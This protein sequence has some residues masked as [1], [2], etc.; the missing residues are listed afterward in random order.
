MSIKSHNEAH[1]YPQEF[2]HKPYLSK[3]PSHELILKKGSIVILFR[4]IKLRIAF[5]IRNKTDRG[6]L[7]PNFATKKIYQKTTE[8][9]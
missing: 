4:N 6:K 5:V 8:G 3:I 2:L 9:K 1:D 7:T